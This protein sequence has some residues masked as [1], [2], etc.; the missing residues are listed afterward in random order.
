M[1]V[2]PLLT[3]GSMRIVVA[4]TFDGMVAHFLVYRGATILPSLRGGRVPAV[5][6]GRPD[7]EVK[8]GSDD[9]QAITFLLVAVKWGLMRLLAPFRFL[10]HRN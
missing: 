2:A 8:G 1:A 6:V 10:F 3:S 4:G 7:K 9:K 5:H